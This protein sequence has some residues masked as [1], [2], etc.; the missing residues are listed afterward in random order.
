M[1]AVAAV[2]L[3]LSVA[4]M[5]KLPASLSLSVPSILPLFM[6][7]LAGRVPPVAAKLYG[8][9]PPL[10]QG[11]TLIDMVVPTVDVGMS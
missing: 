11:D 2:G 9:V 3:A 7:R 6:L 8:G 10:T 5:V 1:L 4:V